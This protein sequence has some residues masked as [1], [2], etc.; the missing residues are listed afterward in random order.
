MTSATSSRSSTDPPVAARINP[1]QAFVDNDAEWNLG[2]IIPRTERGLR[3]QE[4]LMDAARKIFVRDG[5][6]EAKITDIT[7]GAGVASGT[8]YTYFDSKEAIFTAVIKD[9]NNRLY[10]A[11]S[12]P[13]GTTREPLARFEAATRAY[14]HAYQEHAGL[15]AILEQVATIS[16]RFREMR[17]G[18]RQIFRTRSEKGIRRLQTEGRIDPELSPR[19]AAEALT[20][21]VSNFCYVWLVLGEDYDEEESIQTLTR[22]WAHGIGLKPAV[23]EP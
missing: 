12:A 18:I 13:P 23:I 20:S 2:I 10:Q 8:F 15:L 6:L 21:M 19:L 22:I 14:V 1:V 17:R 3:T 16:P 4:R 11:A 5:F 9:V 7:S